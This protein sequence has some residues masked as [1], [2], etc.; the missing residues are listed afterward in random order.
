MTM[1]PSVLQP[2]PSDQ[3]ATGRSFGDPELEALRQVLAS[4]TLTSTR[5]R[6]VRGL[7][8]DFGELLGVPHA[9]ACA[10]GTA[11]IHAAVAA[12]QFEPGDEVITSP[13]TD[14]GA[15]APIL[16]QGLI[17]VFAD[18]DP[19]TCNV[20]PDSVEARIS[21]R[22]RAVIATHLFGNPCD[23]TGLLRV[24]AR[25]DLRIV[26]D[27]SQ[28]YL[29]RHSGQAVGTFGDFGVFSL[30]QGK[31]ITCGE[32]GLIVTRDEVLA[33]RARTY[34]NK[35]WDYADPSPDHRFLA[36]NYRMTELQGAVAR[37]QL[38]RLPDFVRHRRERAAELGASLAGLAGVAL[39]VTQPG[40]EHAYWRYTLRIDEAVHR[41]GA[42]AMAA[43]LAK[44]GISAAA[45][46]I[47]KPAFECEM[48]RRR[49]T[50]GSSGWPLTLADPAALDY[51]RERF[52]GVYEGLER[53]V[54]LPWNER[55]GPAHVQALSAAIRA[56][57][58]DMA[59]DA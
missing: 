9:V 49:Q 43:L 48:F 6:Q 39:P 26:E 4:G 41:G 56:C 13:I 58:A 2:F 37:A 27:C 23:M 19:R 30:Q 53:V 57:L 3:D 31:H 32:G 14:M 40:D 38:R 50:F 22:T 45:R 15:I 16:C 7:E 10:S 5:G 52:P 17:P 12:L 51:R 34:V 46:Y 11:A 44:R 24:A 36:V 18:V 25:H 20:T 59:R 35:A 55:I 1:E 42:V 8:K 54:V 47:K 29:A 28:A 33:R 21:P